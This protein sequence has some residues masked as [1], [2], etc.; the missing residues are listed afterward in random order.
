MADLLPIVPTTCPHDHGEGC[1]A[2][3]MPDV[4]RCEECAL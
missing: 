2:Y 4:A 3:D 1:L